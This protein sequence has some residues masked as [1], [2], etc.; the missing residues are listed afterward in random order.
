MT[1]LKS[2]QKL[3]TSIIIAYVQDNVPITLG[4]CSA[5]ITEDCQKPYGSW[6]PMASLQ[7]SDC[8]DT[9]GWVLVF[10]FFFHFLNYDELPSS[11]FVNGDFFNR[12]LHFDMLIALIKC[13]ILGCNSSI[14]IVGRLRLKETLKITWFLLPPEEVPKKDGKLSSGEKNWWSPKRT[15]NFKK[16][17]ICLTCKFLE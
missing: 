1:V 5:S 6:S 12:D 3:G 9:C 7:H 8:L 10:L 16:L 14:T 2:R 17:K 15:P 11:C 13:F 4:F